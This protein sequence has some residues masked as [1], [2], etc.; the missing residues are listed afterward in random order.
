MAE[1]ED[2][3]TR[4][5]ITHTLLKHAPITASD[6]ANRLNMSAAGIRR[7]LDILEADGFI[8]IDTR[9]SGRS[10]T[11]G[12]PAKAFRLTDRGHLQFGHSYDQLA[13]DA[14]ETLRATGGEEAVRDFARRRIERIVEGVTPAGDTPESVERT[15]E[16]LA[17]AFDRH[18]YAATVRQAGPGI[19]ICHHHCPVASVAA[20]HPELCEAEHETISHLVGVHVQPLATVA[21]GHGICTTNIPLTPV[22]HTPDILTPE[23]RSGS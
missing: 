17:E 19:Q 20:D 1:I 22:Q 11:R 6:L 13:A 14:I 23:E 10:A 18:G 3:D 15:V 21:G 12:R 8:E 2:G 9:R 16:E 7:H 4:R 5:Q